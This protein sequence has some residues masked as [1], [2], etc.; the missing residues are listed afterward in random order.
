[1]TTQ[2]DDTAIETLSNAVP[3]PYGSLVLVGTAPDMD[4]NIYTQIAFTSALDVP[5]WLSYQQLSDAA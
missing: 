3:A 2:V 1:M 4:P 5:V